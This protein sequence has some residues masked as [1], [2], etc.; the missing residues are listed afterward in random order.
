M[1]SPLDSNTFPEKMIIYATS[2]YFIQRLANSIAIS[3]DGPAHT[4]LP[5]RTSVITSPTATSLNASACVAGRFRIITQSLIVFW[6]IYA[7]SS[8]SMI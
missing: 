6:A 3:S 7:T 4:A 8:A 1:I 2:T 5:H